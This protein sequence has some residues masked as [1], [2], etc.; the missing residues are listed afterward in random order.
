MNEEI[1]SVDPTADSY[2]EEYFGY[3]IYIE[4]K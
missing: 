1:D 2:E 4:K 3:Q